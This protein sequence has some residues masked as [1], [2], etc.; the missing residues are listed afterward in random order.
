[1]KK[2]EIIHI[3]KENYDFLTNEYGVSKIA[4]FGSASKDT[5]TEKSDL[6][7]LVEFKKP[8]G[9]KFNQLVIYIENL[10]GTKVDLL[11]PAG[12]DNIRVKKIERSIKKG[13]TYV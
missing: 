2:K 11:T 12:I 10:V 7:L 13:L 1:M 8:I 5:M 6:D 9:F 4:L 3:L